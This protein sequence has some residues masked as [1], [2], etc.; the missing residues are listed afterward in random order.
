[1]SAD[2]LQTRLHLRSYRS[3]YKLH[4]LSSY[5]KY[6]ILFDINEYNDNNNTNRL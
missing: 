5:H 4:L 2:I 1:M 6:N 3:N